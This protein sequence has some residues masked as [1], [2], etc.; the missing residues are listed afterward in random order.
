MVMANGTDPGLKACMAMW[1]A[2]G[3]GTELVGV[4]SVSSASYGLA[5]LE[6]K[7]SFPDFHSIQHMDGDCEIIYG[8]R[9]CSWYNILD[10]RMTPLISSPSYL[11]QL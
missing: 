3:Q 6:M 10:A 5:A 9:Y 4:I 1:A 11:T 8:F 7:I 2:I